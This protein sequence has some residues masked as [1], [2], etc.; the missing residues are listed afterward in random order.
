MPLEDVVEFCGVQGFVLDEARD[1]VVIA[2]AT[3]LQGNG[4]EVFGGED[5]H[6]DAVHIARDGL[7]QRLLDERGAGRDEFDEPAFHLDV[8]PA[9]LIAAREEVVVRSG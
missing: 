1:A 2:L 4:G 3:D 8:L 6:R 9:G 5:A 7:R